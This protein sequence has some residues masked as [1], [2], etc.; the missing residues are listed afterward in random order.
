MKRTP[1]ERVASGQFASASELM[2]EAFR[3]WQRQQ[4]EHEERLLS[5]R[6]RIQ[7]SIDDPRPSIPIPDVFE[8]LKKSMNKFESSFLKSK[9]IVFRPEAE[10][11]VVALY[12]NIADS[13]GSFN[14]SFRFTERLRDA[15]YTLADFSERGRL[16]D[17]IM[18]D[19]RIIVLERKT[20]IAY[21][22]KGNSVIINN[23]FHGGRDWEAILLN[24]EELK[25]PPKE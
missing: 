14:V 10:V 11:D 1:E 2:R 7:K 18:E 22:V 16:H 15:C 19:L 23:I 8:N 5:I 13:G 21:F 9:Q 6:A 24:G 4:D 17:D 3:T 12:K 20:V 25:W